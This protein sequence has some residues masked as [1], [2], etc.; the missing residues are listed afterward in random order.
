MI[1]LQKIW[2]NN[3]IYMEVVSQSSR[4]RSAEEFVSLALKLVLGNGHRAGRTGVLGAATS[5]RSIPT[6]LRYE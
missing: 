1:I 5:A 2:Q 6:S 3:K 4:G